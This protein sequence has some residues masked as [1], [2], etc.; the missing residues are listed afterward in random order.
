MSHSGYY[1]V[2]VQVSD[3]PEFFVTGGNDIFR[4]IAIASLFKIIS[5]SQTMFSNSLLDLFTFLLTTYTDIA[6][7]QASTRQR[8]AIVL[9]NNIIIH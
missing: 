8:V 5:E 3:R 4:C 1:Q 2:Q 7:H 6:H 9:K